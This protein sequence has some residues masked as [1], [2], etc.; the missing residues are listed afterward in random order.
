[1]LIGAIFSSTYDT[2]QLSPCPQPHQPS[3]RIVI[4]S[5]LSACWDEMEPFKDHLGTY[6][7][8]K[9]LRNKPQQSSLNNFQHQ[10]LPELLVNVY[11]YCLIVKCVPCYCMCGSQL[12][13]YPVTYGAVSLTSSGIKYYIYINT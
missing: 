10:Y 6:E 12:L 13:S 3:S 5:Q 4:Y 7:S 8:L 11:S 9:I 2:K 1:M